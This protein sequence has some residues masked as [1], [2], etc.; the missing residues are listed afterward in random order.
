M[1]GYEKLRQEI[2]E[3]F[4]PFYEGEDLAHTIEHADE[5]CDLAL[6]INTEKFDEVYES[7]HIMIA[8]YAHDMF[9]QSNRKLHHELAHD[10]IALTNDPIIEE[11]SDPERM[12]IA[13]AVLEH[14]ASHK[15]KLTSQMSQIIS[16]ADRGVP[17]LDNIIDRSMKFNNG[18]YKQVVEHIKNKYGKEGYVKYSDF[19]QEMFKKEIQI[20]QEGIEEL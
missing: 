14:R 1:K 3:W 4:K 11:L 5:V 19:Y 17:D 16:A 12:T 15:G 18:D 2:R 10:Y 7:K 9:T 13:F 8:A 20:L 6:R